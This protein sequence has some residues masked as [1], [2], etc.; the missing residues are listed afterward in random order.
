MGI[1]TTDFGVLPDGR[2]VTRYT[3]TGA[4]GLAA[5]LLTYGAT[6]QSLCFRGRDMVLGFDDLDGYLHIRGSYQ[7]A[8]IG[9][10][11][12]RI[13]DGRFSLNGRDYDVGCNEN[14]T[15]HLHGGERGFDKQLWTATV[16]AD[17]AEPAVA[18]SRRSP[19]GEEGYPGNLDVTVTFTVT[20]DNV[21]RIAYEARTDADT[22]V[23]LTNHAY[24]NLNGF[25]GGDILDTEL[26]IAADAI[27]P[28][29]D[30]LIPTG[31]LRPVED[32]PFDFRKPKPIGRDIDADDPQLAIG[33]GYDHNYVLN[34]TGLRPV[35][36]ARSPRSGIAMT[37]VTDQ[38]GVQFYAGNAIAED[39]GKGGTPLFRR[40][41]FCL[42]TQHYPD[43]PN[44]PAF[45]ST[46]LRAGEV[47]QTV[48]EYRFF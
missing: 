48:T 22:V 9:R 43:S 32:T 30:R 37:C 27:T 2:P 26:T 10:Y 41:G 46:L 13:A 20:A 21:L 3:L 17:G 38:P 12:N 23:N 31:A 40:Q 29:N 35:A 7:G 19:D 33:G 18:F 15:G 5:S 28:V 24:F 16:L 4:G 44:Q 34:G 1:Q 6:L 47:Y 39:A 36:T 8:T 25:D 14:G 11:G 45:P 42:E